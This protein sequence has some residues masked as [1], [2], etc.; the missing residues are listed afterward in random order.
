MQKGCNKMKKYYLIIAILIISVFICSCSSGEDNMA[1]DNSDQKEIKNYVVDTQDVYVADTDYSLAFYY[2]MWQ[3][4][5]SL[6]FERLET[7]P[8]VL[9]DSQK[10]LDGF[11]VDAGPY[12][13]TK[14][15]STITKSLNHDFYDENS[16]LI[17]YSPEECAHKTI[18]AENIWFDSEYKRLCIDLRR[19]GS[20]FKCDKTDNTGYFVVIPAQKSVIENSE[21][22][23]AFHGPDDIYSYNK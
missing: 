4:A 14:D 3:D 7:F 15:L 22:I 18:N 2:D 20:S 5:V 9:I 17:V 19:S 11:L 13:D 10:E 21:E 8:A 6:P 1:I 23:I 16:L 12:A